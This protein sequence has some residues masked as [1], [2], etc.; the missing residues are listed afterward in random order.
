LS[1]PSSEARLAWLFSPDHSSPVLMGIL[2][3][4][5]SDPNRELSPRQRNIYAQ[6]GRPSPACQ[7]VVE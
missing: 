2:G 5:R 7:S 6:T 4:F 3:D 1:L